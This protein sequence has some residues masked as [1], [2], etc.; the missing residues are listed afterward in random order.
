MAVEQHLHGLF[1]RQVGLVLDD[2]VRLVQRHVTQRALLQGD[3]DDTVNLLW[4]V[5]GPKTCGVAPAASGLL[6]LITTFGPTKGMS[7]AMG[8]ALGLV[9]LLAEALEFRFQ[10]GDAAITLLTTGTGG[11]RR[12]HAAFPKTG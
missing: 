10:F 8:V 11:T 12:S 6:G 9:E 5:R 2:L 1:G 7:L 3:M 4:G